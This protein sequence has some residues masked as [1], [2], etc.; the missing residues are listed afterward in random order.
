MFK[1]IISFLLADCWCRGL[2]WVIIAFSVIE[3]WWHTK[4]RWPGPMLL[5]EILLTSLIIVVLHS[6]DIFIIILKVMN[7][8]IP[9]RIH[10]KVIVKMIEGLWVDRSS[11]CACGWYSPLLLMEDSGRGDS[12]VVVSLK[13]R[14][15]MVL[16][17]CF[18]A[19]FEISAFLCSCRFNLR[20][21]VIQMDLI[22]SLVHNLVQIYS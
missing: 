2:P 14:G 12:R 19:T 4:C 20:L 8:R 9:S 3:T 6:E 10:N 16:Y 21:V 1:A 5:S 17:R 11:T 7:F 13:I 22:K 18:C 15:M